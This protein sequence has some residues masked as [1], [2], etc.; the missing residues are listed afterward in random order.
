MMM[1]IFIFTVINADVYF[2]A[3]EEIANS[4][5]QHSGPLMIS[6]NFWR[7]RAYECAQAF[8]ACLR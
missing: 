1:R 4:K 2:M 3:K 8:P 5:F 7:S 6:R